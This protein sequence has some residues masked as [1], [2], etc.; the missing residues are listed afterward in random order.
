M[1]KLIINGVA[2]FAPRKWEDLTLDQVRRILSVD[3]TERDPDRAVLRRI[4]IA[5]DVDT[6]KSWPFLLWWHRLCAWFL[7]LFTPGLPFRFRLQSW[8]DPVAEEAR[9]RRYP[10]L[11]LR[12]VLIHELTAKNLGPARYADQLYGLSKVVDFVQLG[13]ALL[14]NPLPRV[15]VQ[16]EWWIG[17]RDRMEAIK[18]GEFVWLHVQ[19]SDYLRNE[20]DWALNALIC[21]LWMP[22][23]ERKI[24]DQQ[25][26]NDAF[27]RR[28]ELVGGWSDIQKAAALRFAAGCHERITE[29]Y[30]YV[31][32][33]S[34]PLT[35]EQ[36]ETVTPPPPLEPFHPGAELRKWEEIMLSVAESGVFGPL[37]KVEETSARKVLAELE[38]KNRE[39]E[40]VRMSQPAV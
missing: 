1:G 39:A 30:P 16:K 36:E 31:F 25:A 2:V 24:T 10:K 23:A 5:L 29:G 22:E 26:Y 14:K 21:A 33:K 8:G 12:W 18:M 20:R 34:D 13:D 32:H 6:G 7:G 40:R 28:M 37:D 9:L 4:M 11:Y 27:T 17:P 15:Q 3:A 38:R 19:L 35:E